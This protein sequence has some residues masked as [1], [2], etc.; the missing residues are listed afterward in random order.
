LELFLR[1]PAAEKELA[2]RMRPRMAL[3]QVFLEIGN[4]RFGGQQFGHDG[5]LPPQC[6][7]L[8]EVIISKIVCRD[9]VPLAAPHVVFSAG[10]Y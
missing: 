2:D 9:Q 7:I 5:L 4:Q 10:L 8:S 6:R 1:Q 3:A